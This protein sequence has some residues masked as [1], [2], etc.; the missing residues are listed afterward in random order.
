MATALLTLISG[1]VL[2][3][4][5]SVLHYGCALCAGAANVCRTALI[6][7]SSIYLLSPEQSRSGDPAVIMTLGPG[8]T[9]VETNESLDRRRTDCGECRDA[10]RHA[11]TKNMESALVERIERLFEHLDPD[12]DVLRARDHSVAAK[13][14]DERVACETR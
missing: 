11:G 4:R 6:L 14:S 10:Q 5:L 12:H 2:Y 8:E 1:G 7:D 13:P 9:T 3:E